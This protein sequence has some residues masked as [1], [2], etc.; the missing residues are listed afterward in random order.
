MLADR[1][2]VKKLGR[3]KVGIVCELHDRLEM[4]TVGAVVSQ[5]VAR[6]RRL[7]GKLFQSIPQGGVEEATTNAQT[8]WGT[9]AVV[10]N[11]RL[12][13]R[14]TL[15]EI[16]THW[17]GLGVV[18]A[19]QHSQ[20]HHSAA[21]CL[22]RI[23]EHLLTESARLSSCWCLIE[24]QFLQLLVIDPPYMVARE[25]DDASWSKGVL[26]SEVTELR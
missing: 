17:P 24:G 16:M 22:H 13:H 26:A 23:G 9:G 5:I 7:L 11:I 4:T 14:N 2:K 21:P 10:Q 18:R 1:S 25:W 6:P 19:K 20:Q 8:R 15:G 3:V 12:E